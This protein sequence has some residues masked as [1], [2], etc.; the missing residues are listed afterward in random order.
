MRDVPA[1][2]SQHVGKRSDSLPVET[3]V[4]GTLRAMI[5]EVALYEPRRTTSEFDALGLG[6]G[7]DASPPPPAVEPPVSQ[8]PVAEPLLVIIPGFGWSQG[9]YDRQYNSDVESCVAFVLAD[10]QRMAATFVHTNSSQSDAGTCYAFK[11]GFDCTGGSTAG[12]QKTSFIHCGRVDATCPRCAAE[13]PTEPAAE[14]ETTTS[15]DDPVAEPSSNTQDD[16][17]PGTGTEPEAQP[18]AEPDSTQDEV[19]GTEP[20][21]QPA[22]EPDATHDD[23]PESETEVHP[24]A[25]PDSTQAEVPDTEPEAQPAA[26]PDSGPEG[27]AAQ[28]D[29]LVTE[30]AA[31]PHLA[32]TPTSEPQTE[33]ETGYW[34][35]AADADCVAWTPCGDDLKVTVAGSTTQDQVCGVKLTA[36]TV[37]PESVDTSEFEVQVAIASGAPGTVTIVITRFEQTISS[38]TRVPGTLFDYETA[39]AKTQ[40]RAGVADALSVDLSSVSDL[41]ITDARRH[42]RLQDGTLTISY[43]VVLTDPMIAAT[44]AA[45]AKDTATFS[46]ALVQ[47]VNDAGGGG[48]SLDPSAATVE[49]PEIRTAIE[50]DV[51]IASADTAVVNSVQEQLQDRGVMAAALSAA[52]GT[53]VLA[54]E[55]ESTVAQTPAQPELEPEPELK[56]HSQDSPPVILVSAA[57]AGAIAIICAAFVVKKRHDRLKPVS[58]VLA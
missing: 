20:E 49:P 18:A 27:D 24:A 56:E 28:D 5:S 16:D 6:C 29:Q 54:G 57:A 3:A 47:A 39:A 45:A 38:A 14:P 15:A 44:A 7:D 25:E 19:S 26:E 42:R 36:M 53:A 52:T 37:F 9:N 43:D 33:C 13:E 51:V 55:V 21:A 46:Q 34:R 58:A 32:L 10:E 35:S 17:Q 41:T 2:A 31:E 1:S 48:L 4:V 22:A 12:T 23:D 40:F 50:Y 11:T 8:E 30:P